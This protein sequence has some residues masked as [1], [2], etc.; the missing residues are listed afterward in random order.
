M[1]PL[2][3]MQGITKRFPGVTALERVSLKVRPGSVHA[4]MGENGAGKSTLMKILT[5]VYRMDAGEVRLGGQLATLSDPRAAARHGVAIIHQELQQVPE[6]RVF[7]NFFLGREK[8]TALGVLDEARMRRESAQWL[9]TLGL[10]LDLERPL[11]ELRVA[12]RQFLEIAKA[13]SL[14]ARVLVMDEPTTALSGEEVARLFTVVRRL[15]D[16]GLAV[17]YISH[18]LEEIFA[19]CDE[20]TVLRDGKWVASCPLGDLTPERL[21]SLMVGRELTELYPSSNREPGA[22]RLKVQGL[23]VRGIPGRRALEGVSFEVRQGEIVGLAGLLGA[24]RTEL[25]EALYGVRAPSQVR[26]SIEIAGVRHVPR[27]PR[28]AIRA[29][30][31]FV[32]EDRKGQ[33]LVLTRSVGENTSLVGLG[34]FTR[35]GVL[36]LRAEKRAVQVLVGQLRVKTPSLATPVAS[37][38]GGNQQKVALGKFLLTSPGVFLLDEPTQGVDVGAK[39]EIY[40]L[41][42]TLAQGGAAV[43]LAS[44]DMPEL[45]SLCDRILVLCEGRLSGTLSRAEA[46]GERILELATRFQS[47]RPLQSGPQGGQGGQGEQS[48]EPPSGPTQARPTPGDPV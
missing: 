16:S 39:A 3:E 4:L 6:L 31:G 10:T 38:S 26:G 7:E 24:G 11:R 23:S 29:G 45:L 9:S 34:R 5:G 47:H 43:L 33:S 17:I 27:S 1:P 42:D 36:N 2:L 22:V 46:T 32:T 44:S 35:F 40:A 21:I 14:E 15:R 25:L 41:I 12:E 20:V 19:L 48:H 28:D 30:V 37:L 8:R 18:R 13:L